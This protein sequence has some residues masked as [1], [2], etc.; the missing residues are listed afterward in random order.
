MLSVAFLSVLAKSWLLLHRTLPCFRVTAAL[1][2]I[3]A[4]EAIIYAFIPTTTFLCHFKLPHDRLA[5]VIRSWGLLMVCH[6]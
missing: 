6:D 4:R 5:S 2:I 3:F 1:T